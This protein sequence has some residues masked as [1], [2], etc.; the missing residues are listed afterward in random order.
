MLEGYAQL[1]GG[2]TGGAA[3]TLACHP[4]DL[5]K[6]RFS[7]NEGNP[8]RPQ[9]R[10]Y[11]H[12]TS[13]IV[14]ANGVRAL[15]QGLSP[16]MIAAP[17]SWGLYFHLVHRVRAVLERLEVTSTITQGH[18]FLTNL[19]V[20]CVTGGIVL[21]LTNPLWVCKTRLCLQYENS[22]GGRKYAG[23]ADCLRKIRREEGFRGLFRVSHVILQ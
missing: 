16:A 6:I 9:Y 11:W 22:V 8:N 19:T 10:S 7:A 1:I 14:R 12:A 18:P 5:M 4:F 2:L 3:G 20:G 15:Y 17:L 21:A 13:T 23:L